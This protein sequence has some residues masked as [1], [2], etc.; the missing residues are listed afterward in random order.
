MIEK[1]R[2]LQDHDKCTIK[3]NLFMETSENKKMIKLER[4]IHDH[5]WIA[6]LYKTFSP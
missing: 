5:V 3:F 4:M 2:P 6:Q 1:Q